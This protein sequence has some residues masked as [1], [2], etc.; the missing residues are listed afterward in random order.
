M[1]YLKND[2]KPSPD[3]FRKKNTGT[4][5][6]NIL[7]PIRNFSY[8]CSHKKSAVPL[9]SEKPVL[10]LRSGKNFIVHNAVENILANAKKSKPPVDYLKKETYGK[11][12]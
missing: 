1:G 7:P 8:E 10:G 9:N 5:G 3:S 2:R 12:P 6:S 4:M 11:V